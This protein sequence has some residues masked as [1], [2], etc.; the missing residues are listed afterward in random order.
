MF[1]Q[2]TSVSNLPIL[3]VAFPTHRVP[4]VEHH[5]EVHKM[6]VPQGNIDRLER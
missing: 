2:E 3:A 4:E 6:V 1:D 5:D